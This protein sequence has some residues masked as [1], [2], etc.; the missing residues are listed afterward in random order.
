MAEWRLKRR[1]DAWRGGGRRAAPERSERIP[2]SKNL[3]LLLFFLE[4][5]QWGVK[6]VLTNQAVWA[7]GPIRFPPLNDESLVKTASVVRT[8]Q[9]VRC[10]DY[11]ALLVLRERLG[12]VRRDSPYE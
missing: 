6:R 5:V 11:M 10:G 12:T 9:T 7:N 4:F 2:Q 8:A 3:E 1:Q